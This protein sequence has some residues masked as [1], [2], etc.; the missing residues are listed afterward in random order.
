MPAV[1]VM[2]DLETLAMNPGGVFFALAAV[3]FDPD[4]G[5][6]GA[7]FFALVDPA[8]MTAA[9]FNLDAPTEAWWTAQSE[10]A[11]AFLTA[12][13]REGRSLDETLDRFSAYL[14]QLGPA[15]DLLIWGKGGDFDKPMLD[16]A[17]R[18][19]GKS[20][21]WGPRACRC[22]RTLEALSP[23]PVPRRTTTGVAHHALDDV[24]HQAEQAV[25]ILRQLKGQ[26]ALSFALP[27]HPSEAWVDQ[28]SH[29][30]R[31][32]AP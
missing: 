1:N 12:A 16:E 30:R 31:R 17:Y 32:P 23:E 2:I 29:A 6:L 20:L 4:M 26:P 27:R 13:H 8:S 21:P 7:P 28:P 22:Y 10:E 5:E 15:E 14:S 3:P 18:R 11:R 19:R 24:H 9:G 25:K